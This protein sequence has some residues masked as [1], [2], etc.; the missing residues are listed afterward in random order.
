LGAGSTDAGVLGS[1]L[2]EGPEFLM[3]NKSSQL[4]VHPL[5]ELVSK[6]E[7]LVILD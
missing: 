5:A 6:L 1:G 4:K 2:T 3:L 7:D